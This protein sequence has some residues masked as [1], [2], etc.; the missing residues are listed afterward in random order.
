MRL[1]VVCTACSL[2]FTSAWLEGEPSSQLHRIC[3]LQA[4]SLKLTARG[5]YR[6]GSPQTKKEMTNGFHLSNGAGALA[7]R[8]SEKDIRLSGPN[9]ELQAL[10]EYLKKECLLFYYPETEPLAKQIAASSSNVEL[11]SIQWR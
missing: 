8:L 1:L 5:L 4:S 2:M 6:S 7:K 3:C 9:V 10:P 11:G